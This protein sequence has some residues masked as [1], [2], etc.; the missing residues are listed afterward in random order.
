M[1]KS[2]GC[3]LI[4]S[5]ITAFRI[6]VKFC[7]FTWVFRTKESMEMPFSSVRCVVY[8]PAVLAFCVAK[9]AY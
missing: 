5:G 6:R 8:T 2:N 7:V 3:P 9:T 1:V 4:E